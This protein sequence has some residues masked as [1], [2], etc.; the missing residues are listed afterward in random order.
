LPNS[1]LGGQVDRKLVISL[2]GFRNGRCEW[3]FERG[4]IRCSR[5]RFSGSVLPFG[6]TCTA[7]PALQTASPAY[8]AKSL[9]YHLAGALGFDSVSFPLVVLIIS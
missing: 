7:R 4:W 3:L 8:G 6:W 5:V 1:C 9:S 2:R